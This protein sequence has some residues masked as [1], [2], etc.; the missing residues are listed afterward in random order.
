[1]RVYIHTVAGLGVTA[2]VGLSG[3]GRQEGARDRVE[4]G[5]ALELLLDL[6]LVERRVALRGRSWREMTARV[7]PKVC[8]LMHAMA[9]RS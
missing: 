3:V 2:R 6:C 8:H 9:E 5:R 7:L 1:M 4:D